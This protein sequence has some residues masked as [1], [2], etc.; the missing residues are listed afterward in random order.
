[1]P[2]LNRLNAKV[3]TVRCK[4]ELEDSRVIRPAR[5]ASLD[6]NI[7]TIQ[8]RRDA[9]AMR[10]INEGMVQKSKSLSNIRAVRKMHH[11]HQSPWYRKSVRANVKPEEDS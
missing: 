7:L 1:M 9:I 2:A 4:P 10:S 3:E 8:S 5:K 11:G 6:E